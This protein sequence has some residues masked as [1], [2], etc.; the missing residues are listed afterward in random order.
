MNS[1]REGSD[2]ESI[3]LEETEINH[4]TSVTI[5]DNTADIRIR[6]I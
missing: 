6:Y 2:R 5:V 1:K 3:R 4:E